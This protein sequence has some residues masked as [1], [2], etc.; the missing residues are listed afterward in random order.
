MDFMPQATLA[1]Q[2]KSKYVS[3]TTV[4]ATK[5][6]YHTNNLFMAICRAT[7]DS[8]K[9]EPTEVDKDMVKHYFDK[10]HIGTTKNGGTLYWY[11]DKDGNA[12][13]GKVVLYGE[14][15]KR[16][17][18][19]TPYFLSDFTSIK[20][21]YR[22]LFGE[23]LLAGNNK[24]VIIFESEKSCLL[25]DMFYSG[26]N[27]DKVFV[28]GGGSNGITDELLLPLAARNVV[29]MYDCDTSGR[30]SAEVLCGKIKAHCK[31]ATVTIKDLA[32]ERSDG[33][34]FADY[35]FMQWKVAKIRAD[36]EQLDFE[37][38]LHYLQRVSK[39]LDIT[40]TELKELLCL[41]SK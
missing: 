24:R 13:T 18:K 9:Y 14:N 12:R 3:M 7:M 25:A 5:K 20:G 15:G 6:S 38:R 27:D 36:Y 1:V 8:D 19:T 30:K 2:P 39:K 28:S 10:Y 31:G 32:P 40:I 22:C 4:L 21:H 26:K 35:V 34:D 33:F 23:H 16:D 29:I 37:G 17:R 11:V 41:T